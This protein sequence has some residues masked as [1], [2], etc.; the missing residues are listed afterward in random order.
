MQFFNGFLHN[1]DFKDLGDSIVS[2]LTNF[3]ETL[4]WNTIRDNAKEAFKGLATTLGVIASDPTLWT[5]LGDAIANMILTIIDGWYA[6]VT[7]FPFKDFGTN[8]GKAINKFLSTLNQNGGL[9]T[10]AINFSETAKGIIDMLSNAIEE[11]DWVAFGESL[12]TFLNNI[13]WSGIGTSLLTCA[14]N[15]LKAIGDAIM[16]LGAENPVAAAILTTIGAVKL[17]STLGG[18]GSLLGM[19]AKAKAGW[20]IPVMFKIAGAVGATVLGAEAI[21]H[22]IGA[23]SGDETYKEFT[24]KGFFEVLFSKDSLKDAW[25]GFKMDLIDKAGNVAVTAKAVDKVVVPGLMNQLKKTAN[26]F[27]SFAHIKVFDDSTEESFVGLMEDLGVDIPQLL[28][29]LKDKIADFATSHNED[30]MT[31]EE[32][33]K[34]YSDMVHEYMTICEMSYESA[35]KKL[36]EEL[37]QQGIDIGLFEEAWEQ[38]KKNISGEIESAFTEPLDKVGQDVAKFFGFESADSLGNAVLGGIN[39]LATKISQNTAI[40]QAFANIGATSGQVFAQ[41][42]ANMTTQM[43]AVLD[44]T[45][46]ELSPALKRKLNLMGGLSTGNIAGLA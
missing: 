17:T 29:N 20:T 19:G 33:V 37:T 43:T 45:S 21:A 34:W 13:D 44:G 12:A 7:N 38:H 8:I 4:D 3:F 25:N 35:S 6:F 41:N 36:N 30:F 14:S 22:L 5:D 24:W 11:T 27:G 39:T 42:L 10:L 16:G 28:E 46:M 9:K 15:L 18:V 31:A 2:G 32:K 40:Q 26:F 1:F 23:I